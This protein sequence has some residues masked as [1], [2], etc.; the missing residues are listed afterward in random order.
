[1]PS[2]TFCIPIRSAKTKPGPD[3]T[4]APIAS[5][6]GFESRPI[7]RSIPAPPPFHSA[8]ISARVKITAPPRK[9]TSVLKLPMIS[10]DSITIWNIAAD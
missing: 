7:P 8:T 6:S 9:L 5:D 3:A 4:E 2:G 1:M 10:S